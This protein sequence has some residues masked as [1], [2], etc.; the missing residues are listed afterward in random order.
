MP[1]SSAIMQEPGCC[2]RQRVHIR[3]ALS[4]RGATSPR[5]TLDAPSVHFFEH[6]GRRP[7]KT[8]QGHVEVIEKNHSIRLPACF[9]PNASPSASTA[10]PRSMTCRSRS[11]G[12]DFCPARSQW[13]RQ[14]HDH[15]LYSRLSS[16]RWRAAGKHYHR[17]PAAAARRG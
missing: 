7:R 5:S 1:N 10:S 16:P 6:F 14:D 11:L 13:S 4:D 8:G 12:G 17:R 3:R 9:A 2:E 15:Q